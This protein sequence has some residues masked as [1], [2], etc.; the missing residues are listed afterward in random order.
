MPEEIS[1][2]SLSMKTEMVSHIRGNGIVR[3][4]QSTDWSKVTGKEQTVYTQRGSFWRFFWNTKQNNPKH[5]DSDLKIN[6]CAWINGKTL[7]SGVPKI[8]ETLSDGEAFYL[9]YCFSS[10]AEVERT[11]LL[12]PHDLCKTSPRL[13]KTWLTSWWVEQKRMLLRV[14]AS[15]SRH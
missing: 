11:I 8:C 5:C 10:L 15:A 9:G 2:V 12:L 6:G 14:V 13:V 3:Q 4:D 1:H 7:K